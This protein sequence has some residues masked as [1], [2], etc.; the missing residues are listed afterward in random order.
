MFRYVA[1]AD[2]DLYKNMAVFFVDTN[3]FTDRSANNVVSPT[4]LDLVFGIA[5]RYKDAELA[6]IHEQDMPLDRG[7]LVQRY[8]AIQLRYAFE[9]IKNPL[10]KR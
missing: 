9:W 2:L 7:G 1:H 4:E 5:F 8:T 3:F 6:V 10:K